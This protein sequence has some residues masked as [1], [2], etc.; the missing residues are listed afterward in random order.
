MLLHAP[1]STSAI[2]LAFSLALIAP[3]RAEADYIAGNLPIGTTLTAGGLFNSGSGYSVLGTQAITGTG[4]SIAVKFTVGATAMTFDSARLGLVF[5]AGINAVDLSLVADLKGLPVGSTMETIH[6]GGLSA[7]PS[8]VTATSAA[9]SMLAAGMSY[10][11]VA[12][13]G[14]TSTDVG[15]LANITGQVGHSAYRSG[16]TTGSGAWALAASSPDASF[17]VFGT[18]VAAAVDEPPSGL[19]CGLGLVG[20][21]AGHHARRR[22]AGATTG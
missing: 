10:W 22:R 18:P 14:D 9:H 8:L 2:V 16:P 3:G 12:T 17:A 19:L 5:R 4:Y 15:W 1:R 7:T 6:L 20:L 11:L 13:P 21:V